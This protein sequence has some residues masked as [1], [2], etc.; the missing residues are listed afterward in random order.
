MN[1]A[2]ESL[3]SKSKPAFLNKV[4]ILVIVSCLIPY[5]NLLIGY[6]VGGWAIKEWVKNQEKK[7]LAI[8]VYLLISTYFLIYPLEFKS[9]NGPNWL[10]VAAI[11]AYV[12]NAM[13][14][15]Y[16]HHLSELTGHNAVALKVK[17]IANMPEIMNADYK[18]VHY[19]SAI[20]LNKLS[21]TI[22]L[23]SGD[24]KKTYSFDEI[25]EWSFKKDDG[26]FQTTVNGTTR[27]EQA[28]PRASFYVK[29]RDINHPDWTIE[30]DYEKRNDLNRWMEIFQQNLNEGADDQDRLIE[31]MEKQ[32]GKIQELL[33]NGT[34]DQVIE[35]WLESQDTNHWAKSL[36]L[37]LDDETKNKISGRAMLRLALNRLKADYAN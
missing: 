17:H 10:E 2:T 5:V 13:L 21:K 4:N 34:G 8:G 37:S 19:N 35:A 12:L 9:M 27:W 26:Y 18:N 23:L 6:L 11:F 33:P 1:A 22:F 32:F 36:Y 24:Q 25:R 3:I 20:A 30:F 31:I 15:A 14:I 28:A 16:V 29:V 7:L